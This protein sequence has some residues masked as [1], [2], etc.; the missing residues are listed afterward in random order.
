MD[1]GFMIQMAMAILGAVLIVGGI[2]F[3]RSSTRDGARSM[4]TAG[5]AAGVVMW[6][7]VALTLPISGASNA[8]SP[9]PVISTSAVVTN[10]G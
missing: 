9:D 8:T 3:Y 1:W 2:V 6:A 10:G 4:G 7:F 5:G